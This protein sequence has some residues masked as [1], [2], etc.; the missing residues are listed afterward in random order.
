MVFDRHE[1][2]T[3]NTHN[4]YVCECHKNQ[5]ASEKKYSLNVEIETPESNLSIHY[6]S[7]NPMDPGAAQLLLAGSIEAT[8]P[9]QVVP[10]LLISNPQGHYVAQLPP[11]RQQGLITE[12]PKP[13]L[14]SDCQRNSRS[15][16][17]HQPDQKSR[18]DGPQANVEGLE[19][20][21]A[22]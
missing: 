19:T 2:H 7:D 21:P 12:G 13:I 9:G 4:T 20:S 14:C 1:T 17:E 11:T 16:C 22:N 5:R 6:S 15:V 8:Y 10:P 3:H 18:S